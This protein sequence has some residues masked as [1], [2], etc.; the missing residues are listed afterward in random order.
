MKESLVSPISKISAEIEIIHPVTLIPLG[1]LI[2]VSDGSS[3]KKTIIQ[4][5]SANWLFINAARKGRNKVI[6]FSSSI[7]QADKLNLLVACTLSW[8][9]LIID[10]T[11]NEVGSR[12]QIEYKRGQWM[13][14]TPENVR[15]VYKQLPW[16]REQI[17]FGIGDPNNFECRAE[18]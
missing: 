11:G 16:L 6:K 15:R 5:K 4:R 1:V 9:T 7:T 2:T 17:D 10:E 8:R 12:A 3:E 18:I 14:C 13:P